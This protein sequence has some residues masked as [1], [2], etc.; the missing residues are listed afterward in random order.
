MKP[1]RFLIVLIALAIAGIS[2]SE[3]GG[4]TPEQDTQE[5]QELRELLDD[6]L[7]GASTND[8]DIHRRFWADDLIYTGSAGTRTTKEQILAGMEGVDA[9][10][11]EGE[12]AGPAYHAE[13]LDIKLYGSTAIVAFKLVAAERTGGRMEFYNTGTFLKRDGEWR[14]VAWQATRIPQQE[15]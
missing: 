7:D 12:P 2:C 15:E 6:F 5:K 10:R 13:E 1:L 8:A 14:A 3:T 4:L 11:E 9:E